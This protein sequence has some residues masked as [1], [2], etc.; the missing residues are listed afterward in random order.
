MGS[1]D[2]E[3]DEV[4]KLCKDSLCYNTFGIGCG[5]LRSNFKDEQPAHNVIL[6]GFWID[7]TE[8]TNKRYAQ[9]VVS[10]DCDPPSEKRTSTRDSNSY[11]GNSQYNHYPVLQVNW[12]DAKTYCEWVGGRLPTEAEW[13]YAAG[14]PE[15]RMYPWGEET[16][17]CGKA[18]YKHNLLECVGDTTSGYYLDGASWVGAY[19]MSGNVSEW[20]A[21][22][23]SSYSSQAQTNPIGPVEGDPVRGDRKVIRGG[24]WGS[25]WLEIRVASRSHGSPSFSSYR[26]GFR[27]TVETSG[28]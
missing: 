15:E 2:S 19:V 21:D 22:W 4:I 20:V 26:I 16:P 13:E 12:Y 5:C 27:C 3:I 1:T 8:V 7:Q 18:N 28:H 25:G 23:Y 9:C 17:D 14:G 24:N 11:Y 10:G 6:N